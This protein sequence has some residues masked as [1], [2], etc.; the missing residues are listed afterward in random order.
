MFMPNQ[1][2]SAKKFSE[3]HS[4]KIAFY[5]NFSIVY[6][7]LVRGRSLKKINL[8]FFL[9]RFI[10]TNEILLYVNFVRMSVGLSYSFI[11]LG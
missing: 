1:K 2:K 9:C 5:Q 10:F 8:L 3:N 7:Y 11:F 6:H 4:Q